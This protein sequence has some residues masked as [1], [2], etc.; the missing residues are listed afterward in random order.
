M[1]TQLSRSLT[2]TLLLSWILLAFQIVALVQAE[3]VYEERHTIGFPEN[4]SIT[5][6]LNISLKDLNNIL[7]SL[8]DL[9]E[10]TSSCSNIECLRETLSRNTSILDS[11]RRKEIIGSDVYTG[12]EIIMNSN[13]PDLYSYVGDSELRSLIENLNRSDL[14]TFY[15]LFNQYSSRIDEMYLSGRISS[16]EYLAALELLKRI[17]LEKNAYNI[18]NTLSER[19]L[20]LV[21]VMLDKTYSDILAKAMGIAMRNTSG[22]INIPSSVGGVRFS[23]LNSLNSQSVHLITPGVPISSIMLLVLLA[24]LA[25]LSISMIAL[26]ILGFNPIKN[27]I[28]R[29]ITSRSLKIETMYSLPLPIK[30]YW[31]AV[32]ILSRRIPRSDSETHREYLMRVV[33]ARGEIK[34]FE[35]LTRVYELSRYGGV[36][37]SALDEEAIKS[38]DELSKNERR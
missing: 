33:R 6:P 25:A 35:R 5:T 8:K 18:S 27:I 16:R 30:L 38:F 15:L 20:E 22:N 2:L 4:M 21:R 3:N 1:T 13:T 31:A 34:A 23:S 37:S 24:I 26:M 14:E 19:E 28:S 12:I 10:L 36:S 29:V 11:L 7:S 32:R 17:S 9:Q